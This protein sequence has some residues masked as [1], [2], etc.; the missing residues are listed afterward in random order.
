MFFLL[1]VFC[2]ISKCEQDG[3]RLVGGHDQSCFMGGKGDRVIMR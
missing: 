3:L 2:E 1:Q